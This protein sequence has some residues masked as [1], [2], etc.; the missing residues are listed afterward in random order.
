MCWTHIHSS[1]VVDVDEKSKKQTIYLLCRE[2][3]D[4]INI[5]RIHYKQTNDCIA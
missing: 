2:C 4:K 1:L 5:D 3:A